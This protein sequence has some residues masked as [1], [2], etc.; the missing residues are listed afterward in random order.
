VRLLGVSVHNFD[1]AEMHET[2]EAA[3]ARLP[4]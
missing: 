1:E 4:F 3:D 2:T